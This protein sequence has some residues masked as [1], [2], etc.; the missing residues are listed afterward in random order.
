MAEL[1]PKPNYKPPGSSRY[2]RKPPRW[3]LIIVGMA[4][5]PW[6]PYLVWQ[7]KVFLDHRDGPLR[8]E[9]AALATSPNGKLRFET[10]VDGT[11]QLTEVATGRVLHTRHISPEKYIRVTPKWNDNQFVY[12]EARIRY[13]AMAVQ[14]EYLWNSKTGVVTDPWPETPD[15]PDTS[16]EFK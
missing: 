12:V 15:T 16:H 14:T 3:M 10:G 1:Q 2:L 5:L 11:A 9:S 6:L 7:F 4:V 13:P 8:L